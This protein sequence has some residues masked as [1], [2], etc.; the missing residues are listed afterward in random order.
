M[1]TLGLRT[2]RA[3]VLIRVRSGQHYEVARSIASIRGV[4][5]A[6]AVMGA[7]DVVARIEVEEMR[8][9]SAI[10]T[11]IGNLPDVVTTETLIAAEK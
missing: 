8:A 6:F 4:K 1:E 3:T 11:Q 7:A 9:L 5:S 2:V 10:G